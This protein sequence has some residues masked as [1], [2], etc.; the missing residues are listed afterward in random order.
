MKPKKYYNTVKIEI[1]S[2]LCP[3]LQLKTLAVNHT[4]KIPRYEHTFRG[5]EDFALG[6]ENTKF[7]DIIKKFR[8]GFRRRPGRN[9]QC[10]IQVDQK[11]AK[12]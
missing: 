1:P 4:A 3:K 2:S 12:R 8:N 5:Y 6:Y 7:S 10:S 9:Y 11:V